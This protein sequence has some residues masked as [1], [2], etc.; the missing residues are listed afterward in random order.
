MAS[1]SVYLNGGGAEQ[2]DELAYMHATRVDTHAD[3]AA[4]LERHA[5]SIN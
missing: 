1:T 3:T 2:T 5:E 4:S